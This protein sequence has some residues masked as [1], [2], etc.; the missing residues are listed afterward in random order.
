MSRLWLPINP[1]F[2]KPQ[3]PYPFLTWKPFDIPNDITTF[4][5]ALHYA[6]AQ[7]NLTYEQLAP[8]KREYRQRTDSNMRQ[9]KRVCIVCRDGTEYLDHTKTQNRH[10]GTICHKKGLAYVLGLD[11]DTFLHYFVPCD[12]CAQTFTND[13]ALKN[14]LHKFIHTSN[15]TQAGAS[16]GVKINRPRED[17]T[18]AAENKPHYNSKVSSRYSSHHARPVL[19]SVDNLSVSVSGSSTMTPLSSPTSR[20]PGRAAWAVDT[21]D[22]LS[23]RRLVPGQ[24]S[25][26][27]ATSSSTGQLR[28]LTL[29]SNKTFTK[30]AA[31]INGQSVTVAAPTS[32]SAH[33]ASPP[34]PYTCISGHPLKRKRS[35]EDEGTGREVPPSFHPTAHSRTGVTTQERQLR[36]TQ[37]LDIIY[38]RLDWSRLEGEDL[39]LV[40]AS[41]L[42]CRQSLRDMHVVHR[43]V[44]LPRPIAYQWRT[45]D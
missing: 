31:F 25:S 15:P 26:Q 8:V 28:S 34:P 30:S 24:M 39:V 7:R 18:G 42:Q 22:Y 45:D 35:D 29:P 12:F 1:Q 38:N 32:S 36:L 3:L 33:N 2:E 19:T 5:D 17:M 16:E 27:M 40:V 23:P 41:Y 6:L 9:T 11:E 13:R 37:V 43:P 14:H 4:E 20:L 44:I 10:E 21:T